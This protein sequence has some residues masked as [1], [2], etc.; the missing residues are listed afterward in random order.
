MLE[1]ND[2]MMAFEADIINLLIGPL[3]EAKYIAETDNE[4]F[5]HKIVNLDAL[6]N[7]G[8]SSDLALVNEYLQSFSS[9]QHQKDKKLHELFV[10]AFEFVNNDAYWAAIIHLASYMLS[11]RKNIIYCEEVIS[12]LDQSVDHFQSRRSAICMRHSV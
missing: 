7:Y 4:P 12:M 6:K 2:Y 8:G 3:A 10:M 11:S 5:N 9:N 1:L